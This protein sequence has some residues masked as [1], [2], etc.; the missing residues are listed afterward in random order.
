MAVNKKALEEAEE[1]IESPPA[2]EGGDIEPLAPHFPE[3][4]EE[5]Q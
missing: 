3:E 4:K 5:K 1:V 2:K